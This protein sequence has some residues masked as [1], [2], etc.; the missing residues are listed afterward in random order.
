MQPVNC[1]FHE[2]RYDGREGQEYP[3]GTLSE[4]ETKDEKA[5]PV[6]CCRRYRSGSFSLWPGKN[7][8]GTISEESRAGSSLAETA[9]ATDTIEE[10]KREEHIGLE[11]AW[12]MVEG[13]TFED[14]ED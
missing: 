9:E 6:F 5:D 4:G 1:F 13:K 11:E 3:S 2:F 8:T 7:S 12:E 10:I 14:P